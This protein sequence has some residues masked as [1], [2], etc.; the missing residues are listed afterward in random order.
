MNAAPPLLAPAWPVRRATAPH[1]PDAW[2]T[3]DARGADWQ[4]L[5]QAWLG[6]PEDGFNPGWARLR[7]HPHGLLVES[8]FRGRRQGNAA[9]RLNERTWELGSVF[10]FF[11]Q[12]DGYDRYVELHVTPENQRLQLL[13]PDDGLESFRAGRARLEDFLVND[14][15]WVTSE[16]RIAPEHWAVRVA[17]PFRCLGVA[18]GSTPPAMRAAVCRYD[19][20][21]DREVLSSTARL[22]APNYHLQAHWSRLQLVG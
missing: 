11:L 15:A 2:A 6:Q 22:P 12:A 19:L 7:W 10:E 20:G 9:R 5:E 13:W 14:P 21:R 16:T 18:P 1:F 17:V 8:L 4:P 3:P